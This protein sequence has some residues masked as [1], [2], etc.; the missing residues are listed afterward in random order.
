MVRDDVHFTSDKGRASVQVGFG[1]QTLETG[2]FNSQVADGIVGFSWGGGYGHTLQDRLVETLKVPDVFSLCLSETV[3]A[4]VIGGALPEE[5]L[6]VP[7]VPFTSYSAYNVGVSD[8]KVAGTSVGQPASIYAATIVDSG[9]TFT[10]LPP[11]AYYKARDRWRTVCPWGS[12]SSRGVK[13]QYPDDYCYRMSHDELTKFAPYEFVFGGGATLP[14]P[15]TQ[16]AYEWKTGVWCMGVYNNDHNGAVIGGAT[17]RNH[18]VI[19]DRKLRR[20]A[21]VPSNCGAM[22]EGSRP[23]LLKGGY[24]LA[25]CSAPTTPA[26]PPKPPFPPPSPPP[27]SPSPPPPN[28]PPSPPMSPRPPSPPRP[29]GHP[30]GWKTSPPPPPPPPVLSL[31]DTIGSWWNGF[32]DSFSVVGGW[33]NNLHLER[34]NILPFALA[35][36]GVCVVCI[37]CVLCL[38]IKCLLDDDDDSSSARRKVA[39]PQS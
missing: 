13:G 16:Y 32:F 11:G 29:P 17:M 33:I 37:F 18:E 6:G 27:P 30:P 8:F 35:V 3:G 22:H 39:S 10:Y 7:W 1:C 34:G 19:F 14:V 5:P 28:P 12:C 2:L 15:S 26:R 20:V 23:S 4:M 25:G 21:F 9:T 36:V 24:G 38:A 31:F